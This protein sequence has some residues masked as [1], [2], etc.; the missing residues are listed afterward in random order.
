MKIILLKIIYGITAFFLGATITA[1]F[2]LQILSAFTTNEIILNI[3]HLLF[4][5]VLTIVI[6]RLEMKFLFK[7]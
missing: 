6:Y 3:L 4:T 2:I 5:I 1:L 7:H